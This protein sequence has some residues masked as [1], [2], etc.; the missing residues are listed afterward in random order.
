[1]DHISTDDMPN[2][3]ANMALWII[4]FHSR[5]S[6]TGFAISMILSR[7]SISSTIL[8]TRCKVSLV[9]W[10]ILHVGFGD[11]LWCMLEWNLKGTVI[12]WLLISKSFQEIFDHHHR[13]QIKF[14][15]IQRLKNSLK[16]CWYEIGMQSR[17]HL[18]TTNWMDHHHHIYILV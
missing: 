3:M 18:G 6:A 17:I 5:A 12:V 2:L 4:G 8:S 14:V 9:S 11:I 1:M 10:F 7:D 15:W 16:S 13:L